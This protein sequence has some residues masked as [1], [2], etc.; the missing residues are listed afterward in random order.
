MALLHEH[1]ALV[2]R[3]V[4]HSM[5]DL[6]QLVQSNWGTIGIYRDDILRAAHDVLRL[7]SGAQAPPPPRSRRAKA[8]GLRNVTD[9]LCRLVAGLKLLRAL[10]RPHQIL[11]NEITASLQL[12]RAAARYAQEKARIAADG[13]T[14]EMKSECRRML[15]L[16][17]SLC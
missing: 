12:T 9:L 14:A 8:A 1:L 5:A 15:W 2:R 16:A 7:A 13:Y 6:I 17:S 10:A 3:C 4:G 11:F